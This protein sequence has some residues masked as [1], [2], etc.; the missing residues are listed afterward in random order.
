MRDG[1]DGAGGGSRGTDENAAYRMSPAGV[2]RGGHGLASS[3]QGQRSQSSSPSSPWLSPASTGIEVLDTFPLP[4]ATAAPAA[5]PIPPPSAPPL[6]VGELETQ[7][8]PA[9]ALPRGR[10]R[11]RRPWRLIAS[12]LALIALVL[13]NVKIASNRRY[14]DMLSAPTDGLA[15]IHICES[16][17]RVPEVLFMGSSRT[18]HGIDAPLMDRLLKQQLGRSVLTCNS[19][20]FSS[21]F[22]HDYYMLKRYIEDGFVP[23]LIVENLLESNLTYVADY[24]GPVSIIPTADLPWLGDASDVWDVIPTLVRSL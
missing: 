15:R 2:P 7:T 13:V 4:A 3:Q 14:Y 6:D 22:Q 5:P 11:P 9:P 24:P 19:G 10:R 1:R 17:G 12:C 18:L 16:L 20:D 21:T 23:K 8:L